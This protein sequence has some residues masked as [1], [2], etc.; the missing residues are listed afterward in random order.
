MQSHVI[1]ALSW[2]SKL[3]GLIP[4]WQVVV[5]VYRWSASGHCGVG[6]FFWNISSRSSLFH[7]IIGCNGGGNDWVL[8]WKC[9]PS[10]EL[11]LSILSRVPG[12]GQFWATRL[13][14]CW[15]SPHPNFLI[16]T[17]WVNKGW[18][19]TDVYQWCLPW[20]VVN[21]VHWCLSVVLFVYDENCFTNDR[22]K[23]ALC[24]SASKLHLAKYS[25][26]I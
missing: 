3:R 22:I 23:L 20:V 16:K 18:E 6:K 2:L 7:F 21:G 13:G 4:A 5:E 24:K 26:R 1:W 14:S 12:Y 8:W 17:W 10:R 9:T 25:C 11:K 19:L 15:R